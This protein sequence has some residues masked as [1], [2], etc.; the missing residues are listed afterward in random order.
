MI[1][2]RW[3]AVA[4]QVLALLSAYF[5]LG[6]DLPLRDC[7][8]VV[9]ASVVLNIIQRFSCPQSTWMQGREVAFSLA[10]DLVQ[11][12]VLLGLSG[13]LSNPFSLLILAPVTVSASV[14]ERKETVALSA[15]AFACISALAFYYH[16]IAH[17]TALEGEVDIGALAP[18]YLFC[19]W[20][21]LAVGIVFIAVYVS[22][23]A[24]EARTMRTALQI[25]RGALSREQYLSALGGLAAA[26]A[27]EL[28]TPLGTLYVVV[29]DLQEQLEPEQAWMRED[30]GVMAS[31][32]MRCRDILR[33][34]VI[35]KEI[36]SGEPY[37]FLPLCSLVED[38]VA[39]YHKDGV[40]LLY[41]AQARDDSPVPVVTRSPEIIHAL[42]L[43]AQ[44]AIQFARDEVVLD[45]LWDEAQ[46]SLRIKDNG[47][48]F[49]A[50]VL[51]RLGDPYL[52]GREDP[53]STLR[54]ERDGEHMGLG[55][56]IAVTLLGRTGAET[57]FGNHPDGGALVS[58]VWSRAQLEN[59]RGDSS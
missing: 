47:P 24:G 33:D 57:D 30:L 49:S 7:L 56:F 50:S 53:D 59:Q 20:T 32:I 48:G 25:T 2:V 34:M 26:A 38:A 35:R 37:N 10:F 13:G 11:L 19:L 9:L 29:K 46:V 54:E 8:L 17:R 45:L 31:E 14:L 3:L 40:D 41:H 44:N 16:P 21:A 27:H 43:I 42:G 39:P 23:V 22:N 1:L 6:V 28:G 51:A 18:H 15:L 58:I 52:S 12:S 4:G 36:D 55:V 5:L